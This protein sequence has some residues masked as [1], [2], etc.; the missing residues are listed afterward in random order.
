MQYGRRSNRL[1]R[2]RR[3][4]WGGYRGESGARHGLRDLRLL[5]GRHRR[6]RWGRRSEVRRA[7]AWNDQRAPNLNEIRRRQAVRLGNHPHRDMIAV[8][9]FGQALPAL[10]RDRLWAAFYRRGAADHRRRPLYP[11]S[12]RGKGTPEHRHQPKRGPKTAPRVNTNCHLPLHAPRRAKS[13][14][15]WYAKAALCQALVRLAAREPG[16]ERDE[17]NET[18]IFGQKAFVFA[19]NTHQLLVAVILADRDDQDAAWSERVDQD[20][21]DFPSRRS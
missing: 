18:E 3:T 7:S 6:D 5:H 21:R 11:R 16:D 10:Y 8:G 2:N 17:P 19:A 20:R 4:V 9:D 12:A 13:S 14:A 1:R 15:I